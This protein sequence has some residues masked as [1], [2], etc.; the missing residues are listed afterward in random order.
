LDVVT[1]WVI[2]ASTGPASLPLGL[3]PPNE[4]NPVF[5]GG[6]VRLRVGKVEPFVLGSWSILEN[7]DGTKFGVGGDVSEEVVLV[8]LTPKGEP[9]FGMVV[10]GSSSMGFLE[11]KDVM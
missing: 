2:L 3:L 9:T 1:P 7:I 11:P 5:V 4:K 8:T 10:G 6:F